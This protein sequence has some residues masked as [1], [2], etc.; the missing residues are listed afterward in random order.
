MVQF[1]QQ[2]SSQ[3]ARRQ[4]T[5]I[6]AGILSKDLARHYLQAQLAMATEPSARNNLTEA[7]DCLEK[8]SLA[9]SVP[10]P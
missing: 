5:A 1:A 9:P 10:D 6:I 8:V 2:D 3:C 4:C 7:L